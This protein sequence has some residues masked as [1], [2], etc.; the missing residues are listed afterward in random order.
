[1]SRSRT[2]S[3]ADNRGRLHLHLWCQPLRLVLNKVGTKFQ[4]A[5]YLVKYVVIV[6]GLLKLLHGYEGQTLLLRPYHFFL[7]HIHSANIR[8]MK[9][10][11]SR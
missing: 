2:P 10:E 4:A 3:A 7:L 1:M 11:Q 8:R 6:C 5:W 9:Q